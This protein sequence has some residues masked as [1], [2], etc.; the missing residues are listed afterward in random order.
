[1]TECR[2]PGV[3]VSGVVRRIVRLVLPEPIEAAP[4]LAGAV[5][6]DCQLVF[7]G[8]VPIDLGVEVVGIV[9]PFLAI[10]AVIEIYVTPVLIR[11]TFP[12]L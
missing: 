2:V 8:D 9:L 3:V 6:A 11:L 1:M 7:A 4:L 12:F 10:A 5:I